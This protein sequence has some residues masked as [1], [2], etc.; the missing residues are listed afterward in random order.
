[1]N[2]FITL[3]LW[4]ADF[5]AFWDLVAFVISGG[6][7]GFASEGVFGADGWEFEVVGLVHFG[8]F[9]ALADGG[10]GESFFVPK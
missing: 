7:D 2:L 8:V 4:F 6:D 1:V 9:G 10:C 5:F 3:G